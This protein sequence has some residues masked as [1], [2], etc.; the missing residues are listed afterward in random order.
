MAPSPLVSVVI[1]THNRARLARRAV[2]S[3]L[4]QTVSDLEVLVV[5]DASTDD[6]AAVLAGYDD[7]R[8]RVILR[9]V[10]GGGSAARNTGIDASKGRFVAFLDSDD[11]WLPHKLERQ[12]E[13]L[14]TSHRSPAVAVSGFLA[15]R[16]TS[17]RTGVP[18]V[19]KGDKHVSRLLSLRGGPVTASVLTVDRELLDAGLRFDPSLPA[20][21]DLDFL[22]QAAL[23][24]CAIVGPSEALVHKFVAEDRPRV[25]SPASEIAARRLLLAKYSPEL[26]ADPF[27]AAQQHQALALA[28]ARQGESREA[29]H[30]MKLAASLD[31]RRFR[32]VVLRL[33]AASAPKPQ[34]AIAT[35]LSRS[36]NATFDLARRRAGEF[37]QDIRTSSRRSQRSD[38][39]SEH[40]SRTL[41]TGPVS[42]R[43]R[44]GGVAS[45]DLVQAELDLVL[46]D[47]G[48]DVLLWCVRPLLHECMGAG[49]AGSGHK[50]LIHGRSAAALLRRDVPSQWISD[51][52]AL[53]ASRTL[54]QRRVLRPVSEALGSDVPANA[55][56]SF[57]CYRVLATRAS[58]LTSAAVSA[59]AARGL[60]L[61]AS[62]LLSRLLAAARARARADG[63]L[64]AYR[65][66]VVVVASQHDIG[67]RA[68][69]A[70]ARDRG[71]P[72]VYLPHAPVARS[73][74]YFDLPVDAA[75]L[76]GSAEIDLY[77][78]VGADAG[79]L[80]AM[81]NPAVESSELV[82]L[83]PS[84]PAVLAVSPIPAADIQALVNLVHSALDAPVLIAPHPRSNRAQLERMV[85]E[86][87]RLWEGRTLDLLRRGPVRFLQHSSG[88]AWEALALGIPT[89]Q[90]EWLGGEPLYPLIS[91]EVM[92]FAHTTAELNSALAWCDAT[93]ATQAERERLIGWATNWCAATGSTAAAMGAAIVADVARHGSNGRL[94]LDR[95]ATLR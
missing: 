18:G 87:W 48:P 1:P 3:A 43:K 44:S 19:L 51:G 54:N 14:E 82:A 77:I 24:G 35:G 45:A 49:T 70:A 84:L 31:P 64:D 39:H 8:L 13:V 68:L 80:A 91:D 11:E 89:I 86:G 56:A 58:R 93:A 69:I 94:V 40:D 15:L 4:A 85:P 95:W 83:D 79:G 21:Q 62:T 9:P 78:E 37:A 50:S 34:R 72:T 73:P 76:R 52:R 88:V 22:I 5:D 60:K 71:I 27:A 33:A 75:G 6:T 16:G 30:H 74:W 90:L 61:D 17:G 36:E 41:Q 23:R 26:A 53:F 55:T 92:P 57:A 47:V 42:L 32:S 29:A 7:P 25:F 2:D 66:S 10:V 81:G 12:L 38:R 28:C 59:A 67:L 46:A 65:P 20:L 63:L